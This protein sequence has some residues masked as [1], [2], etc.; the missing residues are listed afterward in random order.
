MAFDFTPLVP[1]GSPAPAVRWS[2]PGKYN[3]TFGNNDPEGLAVEDLQAAVQAA[4]S[5]EGRRLSD[6]RLHMGPQGYKPLRDFLLKKLKRD[7]GIECTADDIL[8]T[9]GSLQGLDL[10]NGALLAPG[11]TIIC[12]RDCYEGTL[13]RYTRRGINV[14]GIPL[15]KGGMR[16]DAL[17]AALADLKSKGVR[18][19]FIYTIATIQNPTATIL[20]AGRRTKLLA[21]AEAYGVPIFEDDCYADL[22]WNGERPP[23]IYSMS[24]TQ[25]V[26]HIGSFSKTIA[27]ALRVGFIVAPWSIMSR[28]LPLKTDAGSGGLEQMML[29]EYC[30]AHFAEHVPQLRKRFRA[31]LDTLIAALN[32]QFGTAAEFDDP[33]GGIFLWVKLPDNV[34]AM[35]LREAALAAGVVINPGPEWSIDKA[36]S[37][38]RIRLCFASPTHEEIRD[39]IALLA[40][41]CRKEFGVPARSANI[42]RHKKA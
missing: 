10:V 21:L 28:L 3:F 2:P 17:E 42:E 32:E 34:D 14:V 18:P 39:G 19:K 40:E 5:R 27:P 37:K 7:A 38:S 35:K 4:L 33:P 16:M 12:E 26:I 20:D 41:V 8:L 29:A 23:A 30:E 22:T 25:N 13:N 6:Y 11:D 36:T 15:D 24:R 31:K 9:S 1:A